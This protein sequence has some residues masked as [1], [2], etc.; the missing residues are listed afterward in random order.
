VLSGDQ[1]QLES[2]AIEPARPNPQA[3]AP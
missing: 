1:F 3:E 2:I